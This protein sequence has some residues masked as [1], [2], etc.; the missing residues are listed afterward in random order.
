M[1]KGVFW[2]KECFSQKTCG[3]WGNV[4][5]K[6]GEF[7]NSSSG[8]YGRAKELGALG[9]FVGP[10][11]PFT[12]IQRLDL[13]RAYKAVCRHNA[14]ILGSCWYTWTSKIAKF[15]LCRN[16]FV[17]SRFIILVF[18]R[19]PSEY[20]QHVQFS[21]DMHAWPIFIFV[22]SL[23]GHTTMSTDWSSTHTRPIDMLPCPTIG[24]SLIPDE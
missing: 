20:P 8:S 11:I 24:R 23:L 21:C 10:R 12:A 14:N 22:D 7:W 5:L 2:S 3:I 19:I 15:K 16:I 13:I 9:P 17:R 1:K 6:G 4:Q 18:P